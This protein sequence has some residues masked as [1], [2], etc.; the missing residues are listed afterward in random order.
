[1]GLKP[2][3][4]FLKNIFKKTKKLDIYDITAFDKYIDERRKEEEIN[5][6]ILY[7]NKQGEY[8]KYELL[9]TKSQEFLR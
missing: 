5:F 6:T 8:V 2:T 3:F 1:M 4:L 7:E 9:T